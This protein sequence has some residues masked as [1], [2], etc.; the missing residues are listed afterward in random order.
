MVSRVR[1]S[2]EGKPD[3]DLWLN[4]ATRLSGGVLEVGGW[5]GDRADAPAG[6]IPVAR[7]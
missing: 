5:W 1:G 6:L 7:F 4:E 2:Q 3:K